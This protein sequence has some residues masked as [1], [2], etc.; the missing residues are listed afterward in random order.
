MGLD[1]LSWPQVGINA[2]LQSW[3]KKMQKAKQMTRNPDIAL[4]HLSYW[5]DNGA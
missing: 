1:Y 3:G 2:E 4:S 5:T